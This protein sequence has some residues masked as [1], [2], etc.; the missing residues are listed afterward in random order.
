MRFARVGCVNSRGEFR[1]IFGVAEQQKY[2]MTQGD[3]GN[4]IA[5]PKD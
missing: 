4:A 3:D 1:S 2:A 5:L